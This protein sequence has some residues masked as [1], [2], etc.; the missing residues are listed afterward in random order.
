MRVNTNNSAGAAQKRSSGVIRLA[1]AV[2]LLLAVWCIV[3][4]WISAIPAVN[5]RQQWLEKRGINAGAMYYT[6]LHVMESILERNDP[7]GRKANS[8]PTEFALDERE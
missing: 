2:V 5:A 6:E 3:L 4:P 8:P 7:F 1:F